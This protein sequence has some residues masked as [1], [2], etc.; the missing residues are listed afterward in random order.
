MLRLVNDGKKLLIAV[1]IFPVSVVASLP[2]IVKAAMNPKLRFNIFLKKRQSTDEQRALEFIKW[3][4]NLKNYYGLHYRYFTYN[5]FLLSGSAVYGIYLL[6]NRLFSTATANSKGDGN[7]LL[8]NQNDIFNLYWVYLLVIIQRIS[9]E[10]LYSRGELP[11]YQ[12]LLNE[13]TFPL[14]K[15]FYGP[16][17]LNIYGNTELHMAASRKDI[18]TI[19]TLLTPGNPTPL[20]ETD[21]LDSLCSRIPDEEDPSSEIRDE[22][23]LILEYYASSEHRTRNEERRQALTP[24]YH[25]ER[26]N[27]DSKGAVEPA[28]HVRRRTVAIAS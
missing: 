2:R 7:N 12:G 17:A 23:A 6:H 16:A 22:I 24:Q 19:R 15:I 13:I 5:I 18:D 11:I 8:I 20:L 1:A 27:S 10:L 4:D 3:G 28:S 25:Q 21:S 26:V 14:K 9:K